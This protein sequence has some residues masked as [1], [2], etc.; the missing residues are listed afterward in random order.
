[1]FPHSQCARHIHSNSRLGVQVAL[2][3][4]LHIKKRKHANNFSHTDKTPRVL[5][6]IY[7]CADTHLFLC[8]G[9]KVS[10]EIAVGSRINSMR[11]AAGARLCAKRRSG[12]LEIEE[13]EEATSGQSTTHQTVVGLFSLL[14]Y[15][16]V[17]TSSTTAS[18]FGHRKVACQ[19]NIEKSDV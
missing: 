19:H 7:A 14:G 2:S 11:N 8:G 6:D 9:W 5:F 10:E 4:Y 15:P 13:R 17:P 16:L 12:A 3:V 18:L 1:M